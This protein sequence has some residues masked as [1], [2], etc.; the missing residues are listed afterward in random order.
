MGSDHGGYGLKDTLKSVILNLGH[1]VKDCGCHGPDA[2]DY[3]VYAGAVTA[4]VGSRAVERGIL[5]CGTGI[6]MSIA[7]NRHPGIRA[8]LC[9][10]PYTARMSRAHNDSNV[11]CLGARVIGPGLAEEMVRIWLDTPF[12]GG[13][14][15]RRLNLLD[16][17]E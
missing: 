17:K 15:Q 14:H 1:E 2:T 8:A 12:E 10:E 13:R 9:H 11:L 5:I 16:R 3:P 6:G 7:A 4:L